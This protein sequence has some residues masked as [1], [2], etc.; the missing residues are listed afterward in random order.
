MI[1]EEDRYRLAWED[2]R[3]RMFVEL[4]A[5]VVGVGGPFLFRDLFPSTQTDSIWGVVVPLLGVTL[6]LAGI[7][8]RERQ[9]CP[10]CGEPFGSKRSSQCRNC[11]LE[12]GSTK[13]PDEGRPYTPLNPMPHIQAFLIVGAI[14]LGI[15]CFAITHDLGVFLSS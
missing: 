7:F 13:D 10:R 3:S 1:D 11:G 14:L 8:Y 15:W 6:L 9:P 5:A 4:L 12:A 2:R